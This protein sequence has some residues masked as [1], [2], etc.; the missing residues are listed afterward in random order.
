MFYEHNFHS[1]KNPLNVQLT[2]NGPRGEPGS[3]VLCHVV[4]VL[5]FPVDRVLI[6]RPRLEELI[7]KGS[8][9]AHDHAT[10][11]DVPVNTLLKVV[12]L[13]GTG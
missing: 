8:A 1:H 2:V 7:V 3:H 5:N 12:F 11:R 10:K 13:H 6:L 9:C 4:V